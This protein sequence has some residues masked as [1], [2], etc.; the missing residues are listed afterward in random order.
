MLELLQAI[1]L[2][3]RCPSHNIWSLFLLLFIDF[4]FFL[5]SPAPL[6]SLLGFPLPPVSCSAGPPQVSQGHSHALYNNRPCSISL[7]STTGSVCFHAL[8]PFWLG[9]IKT[10]C[11]LATPGSFYRLFSLMTP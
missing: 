8:S 7:R 11:I 9:E 1:E 10:V 6:F 4:S 5:S 2:N 3:P